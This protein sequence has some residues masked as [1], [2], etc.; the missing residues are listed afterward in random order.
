MTEGGWLLLDLRT[1]LQIAPA[2]AFGLVPEETL[3][4]VTPSMSLAS[5]SER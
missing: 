2:I 4:I 3:S 5:R 1:T